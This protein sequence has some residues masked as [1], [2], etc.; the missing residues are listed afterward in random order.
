MK[1]NAKGHPTLDQFSE[2]GFVDCVLKISDL[3]ERENTY[4]FHLNATYEEKDLGF[5]VEII[6]NIKNGFDA[7]WGLIGDHVYKKGVRFIRSGPESDLLVGVLA[8]LYGLEEKPQNM[9][10]QETYTCI[11]LHQE[12]INM[13]KECIKIK[14]FGRD[15]GNDDQLENNYNESFFNLDLANGFVYWNEKDPDYRSPLIRGLTVSLD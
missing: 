2:D 4:Y 11:A 7:D 9:I 14:L 10:S 13:E 8:S 3:M 15:S 12:I 5:D 6:K 1:V